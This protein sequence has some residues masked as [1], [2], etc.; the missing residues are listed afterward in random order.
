VA[1]APPGTAPELELEFPDPEDELD[2]PEDDDETEPSVVLPAD[3]VV[4][5]ELPI[6]EAAGVDEVL[7]TSTAPEDE[8]EGNPCSSSRVDCPPSSF[9]V[10]GLDSAG[11]EAASLEGI[12]TIPLVS[13]QAARTT[14]DTNSVQR[15]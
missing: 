1:L 15:I 10:G 9:G 8:A 6:P 4:V 14:N 2:E 13:P 3:H 11:V 7:D 12:E 5:D